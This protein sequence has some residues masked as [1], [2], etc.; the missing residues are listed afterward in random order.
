M[1][2]HIKCEDGKSLVCQRCAQTEYEVCCPVGVHPMSHDYCTLHCQM[3]IGQYARDEPT[4]QQQMIISA[5]KSDISV[6]K[7]LGRRSLGDWQ[8]RSVY[9]DHSQAN[10]DTCI[11]DEHYSRAI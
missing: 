1:P 10:S 5:W 9:Q 7:T 8:R 3:S 4:A 2:P 6:M 11:A